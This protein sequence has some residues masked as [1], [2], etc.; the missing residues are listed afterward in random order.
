MYKK[1]QNIYAF[2]EQCSHYPRRSDFV[3]ILYIENLYRGRKKNNTNA[4]VLESAGNCQQALLVIRDGIFKLHRS[5]E[6]FSKE[7]IPP[8]YVA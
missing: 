3:F 4:F 6:I 1:S 5:P 7:S 8:A 2:L